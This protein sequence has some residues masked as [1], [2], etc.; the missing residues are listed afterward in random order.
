[1]STGKTR[2]TVIAVAVAIV[3]IAAA[4]LIF[5]RLPESNAD[6]ESARDGSQDSVTTQ[7]NSSALALSSW[8]Y[9]SDFWESVEE[10]DATYAEMLG[11]GSTAYYALKDEFAAGPGPQSIALLQGGE[12]SEE[13]G[14]WDLV[15]VDCSTGE[16]SW[17]ILD[18]EIYEGLADVGQDALSSRGILPYED[19]WM[20]YGNM[21]VL[22]PDSTSGD[23][24]SLSDLGKAS[25]DDFINNEANAYFS[26]YD[27]TATLLE[28]AP[29]EEGR[30]QLVN[31]FGLGDEYGAIKELIAHKADDATLSA[32]IEEYGSEEVDRWRAGSMRDRQDGFVD[33]IT[34]V[35]GEYGIEEHMDTIERCQ[36]E[37][38]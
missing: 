32:L 2:V 4:L 15:I 13:D 6:G 34:Q 21:P 25:L 7:S 20:A 11:D 16:V 1:M 33:L 38:K 9:F 29:D 12:R 27:K 36:E 35:Y 22:S 23:S 31:Y 19:G 18:G 8:E 14:D 10:E 30:T 5:A 17:W 24:D 3:I 37:Y 26:T 28:S